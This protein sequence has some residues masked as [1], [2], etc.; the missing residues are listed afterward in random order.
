MI[1]INSWDIEQYVYCNSLLTRLWRLNFEI[2]LVFLI[3]PFFLH[4]QKVKTKI[5][6]SCQQKEPFFIIFEGLSLKQI[7]KKK[8][9]EGESP[10]LSTS[11]PLFLTSKINLDGIPTKIN[12]NCMPTLHCISSLEKVLLWKVTRYSYQ[13]SYFLFIYTSLYIS[14]YHFLQL[15]RTSFNII[16]TKIFVTNFLFLT[17]SPNPSLPH[18][19]L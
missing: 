18:P 13:F 3:K 12:E 10:T 4:D 14:R 1:A 8:I 6:I 16:W 17:D 9:L 19:S 2:D 15:F 11:H 7:I 5:L